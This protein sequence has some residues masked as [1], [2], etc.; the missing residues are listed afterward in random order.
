MNSH[1]Q[2]K[3]DHLDILRRENVEF[4]EKK[5]G[6]DHYRW[7]SAT[8]N[9]LSWDDISTH[10]LFLGKK[11]DFP[12]MISSMS[13]GVEESIHFNRDLA[14]VA[15]ARKVALGMGSIRPLF[16]SET[17]SQ[18]YMSLRE[19][20]PDIPLLANIGMGQI[21][22]GEWRKPLKAILHRLQVNGLIVHFNKVQELVQP[23]GDL[24]YAHLETEIRLLS[25]TIDLPLI[26][27]EV[28]HG[29]SR[30]DIELLTTWG[31]RFID[32]AGAGGTSWSRVEQARLG[33]DT[34]PA[35]QEWGTPTTDCLEIMREF[36][37]AYTIASGGIR[38]GDHIAKA[39][40]LGARL[41][42]SATPLYKTWA[43]SG[44]DGI[45]Q[46]LADWQHTLQ[47]IMFL[48]GVA[49]IHELHNNPALIAGTN[50]IIH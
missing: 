16:H 45:S 49:S 40:A 38:S 12:F 22:S 11:L 34:D 20:T 17:H 1:Q 46:L 36:P 15:N 18:S 48:T 3:Q 21:A 50:E 23:K 28:G 4:H 10:T 47:S 30:H 6:F 41:T 13:G 29:F 5:S 7:N 42:A 26:A 39:L 43:V 9:T 44:A 35:I 14:T 37:Y 8:V 24:D 27:K 32:V 25:E 19:L 33:K 2:R 31:F